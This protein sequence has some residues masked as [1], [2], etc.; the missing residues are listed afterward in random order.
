MRGTVQ[1]T[2]MQT[3]QGHIINRTALPM[4]MIEI[5][6]KAYSSTERV[7]N[8]SPVVDKTLFFCMQ[9]QQRH[10]TST[11]RQQPVFPYLTSANNA[12]LISSCLYPI[13]SRISHLASQ[14]KV[15]A[16][17][18]GHEH[19]ARYGPSASTSAQ[20]HTPPQC[21]GMLAFR[22]ESSMRVIDHKPR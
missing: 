10:L 13:L 2:T 20:R 11:S 6:W 18:Q 4:H 7:K 17:N 1:Q 14:V 5:P 9:P 12:P 8:L 21:I 3:N 19:R 22:S 15:R 16:R